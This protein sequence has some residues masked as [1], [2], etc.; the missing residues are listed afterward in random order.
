MIN[1]A[2]TGGESFAAGELTRI[3]INHPDSN[4]KWIAS[5]KAT[6]LVANHHNGLWGECNIA[7]SSPSPHDI[8]V[9]FNCDASTAQWCLQA[10]QENDK[11]RIIDLTNT[12]SHIDDTMY[13]LCEINRK[14]MVHD[15][16]NVVILPS[17]HAMVALLALIPLAKN[18][19]INGDININVD[20]PTLASNAT[21]TSI[22]NEMTT[23]LTAL[24]S[25][26][27]SSINIT[28]AASNSPRGITAT[29]TLPC[30]VDIDTLKELY[31]QYYDDHNFT[32][33]TNQDIDT[34][35]VINTNKCLL[36]LTASQGTLHIKA[37]AD[38]ML[39]GGAGNAVHVM[40]LLFGLHERTGL[41][42]KAQVL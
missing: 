14:F 23:V 31:N 16:Y 18:L 3:L 38:A 4:I 24:Q 42:L 1:I 12:L 7:F 5:N 21:T 15:C 35:H 22:G 6:G 2:I 9:I 36:Y 27:N 17:P 40:N 41:A 10:K 32:F 13:G 30:N 11:L 29:I 20:C 26:F 37:V 28:T 8:D 34:S 33:I 19:L 39:K 25:S